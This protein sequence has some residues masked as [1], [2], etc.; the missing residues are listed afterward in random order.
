[1]PDNIEEKINGSIETNEPNSSK[2]RPPQHIIDQMEKILNAANKAGKTP[3]EL[4]DDV[5]REMFE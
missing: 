3:G 4:A 2:K 1:M 5:F